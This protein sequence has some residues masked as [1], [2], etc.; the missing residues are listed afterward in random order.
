MRVF[1][2]FPFGGTTQKR[3]NKKCRGKGSNKKTNT[4]LGS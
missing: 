3:I 1:A 2:C 4:V